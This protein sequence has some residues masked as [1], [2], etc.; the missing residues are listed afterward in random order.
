LLLILFCLSVRPL[1]ATELAGDRLQLSFSDSGALLAVRACFPDCESAGRQFT[2][3]A[4]DQSLIEFTGPERG[5]RRERRDG[6]AHTELR[7]VHDGMNLVR[8]YTLDNA[9]YSLRLKLEGSNDLVRIQSGRGLQ[10]PDL[11]G[12]GKLLEQLR[13]QYFSAEDG[14]FRMGLDESPE[15]RPPLA[16]G[17]WFGFRNRYWTMMLSA[18]APVD[19]EYATGPDV[20]NAGL[21]LAGLPPG[22]TLQMYLGPVEPDMLAAA[23]PQLRDTMFAG[24]WF[25][26]RWICFGLYSLLLWIAM[27]I[28]NW[29]L[30]IIALSLVVKVLMIPLNKIADHFQHQVHEIQAKLEPRLHDIKK[31]YKGAEQSEQILVLH[32]EFGVTPLYSLKSLF[33]V[34]ILIPVFIG[35]F[36]MLAENIHLAGTGFLWVTDLARP[37]SVLRLPFT[38]PF[39]GGYLNLLPFLMTGLSVATSYLHN[40]PALTPEMHRRQYRNL[41]IMAIAFFLLF[42]TFPAGMVLYWTTNNL[43]SVIKDLWPFRQDGE[44]PS[45]NHPGMK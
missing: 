28:P 12:F 33:G 38:V 6:P 37:D 30:A 14:V 18:D 9:G 1:L 25:W 13:Y 17:G 42:Y 3:Y 7:F 39:F 32:R 20:L 22:V 36:D 23:D 19:P 34:M 5:W 24:L 26:L 44:Q 16:E 29:G 4:G 41:V 11:P 40:P 2:D 45:A 31:Q 10:P 15:D 35:A 43:I 21:Q 27:L 8:S